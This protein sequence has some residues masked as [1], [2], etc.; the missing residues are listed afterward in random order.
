M[1]F[2]ANGFPLVG[3]RVDYIAGRPVAV[4]VYK[5][6]QH[7]VNVF[8]WPSRTDEAGGVRN[9]TPEGY[10]LL[11]WARSGLTFWAVSDVNGTDLESLAQ[12]F[13]NAA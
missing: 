7:T 8:I 12:L 6:R 9:V 1:D 11:H 13:Q 2:T 3:G 5:R 4:L 10:H